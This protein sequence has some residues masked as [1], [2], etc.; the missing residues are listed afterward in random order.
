MRFRNEMKFFVGKLIDL[1]LLDQEQSIAEHFE[2][3]I[4]NLRIR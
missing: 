2:R 1:I 3:L 4:S